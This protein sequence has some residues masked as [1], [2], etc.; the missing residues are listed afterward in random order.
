MTVDTGAMLAVGASV[1]T[2]VN[3]KPLK[4]KT[5]VTTYEAGWTDTL[6]S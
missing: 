4:G 2:T 1:D 5:S 3:G 6:G